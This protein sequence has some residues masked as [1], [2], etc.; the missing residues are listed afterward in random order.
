METSGSSANPTL[1]LKLL[2]LQSDLARSQYMIRSM[3]RQRLSKLTKFP[4]YYLR[5]SSGRGQNSSSSQTQ[6]QSQPS[7]FNNDNYPRSPDSFLSP[8]EHSFVLSH[9]ALLSQHFATSFL[10]SFPVQLRKLDD[11]AGGVSMVDQPSVKE[12]VCVRCLAPEVSIVVPLGEMTGTEAGD[13]E[14]DY[15]SSQDVRL[16]QLMKRGEIWLVRWEG[17]KTAW[18]KGD[19]EVL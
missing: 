14:P 13:W 7:Q 8:S 15:A 12:V 17:V 19:V 18:K 6:S 10:S 16:G 4:I 11:T 5:L 1:N 9:F 2:V 3:L